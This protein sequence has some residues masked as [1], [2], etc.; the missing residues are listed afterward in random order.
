MSSGHPELSIP[1]DTF[2]QKKKKEKGKHKF[3]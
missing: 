2:S 1:S 3:L